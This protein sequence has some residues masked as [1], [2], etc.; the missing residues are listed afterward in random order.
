MATAAACSVASRAR[1]LK[2]GTSGC[3]AR[4]PASW[5]RCWRSSTARSGQ[6]C[7]SRHGARAH[8]LPRSVRRPPAAAAVVGAAGAAPTRGPAAGATPTGTP[9]GAAPTGRPEL[10]GGARRSRRVMPGGAGRAAPGGGTLGRRGH[11]APGSGAVV[12]TGGGD[13]PREGLTAPQQA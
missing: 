1:A 4:P 10:T 13:W 8:Q 5:R 7:H 2:R 9:A 3:R 11:G 12:G 6:R